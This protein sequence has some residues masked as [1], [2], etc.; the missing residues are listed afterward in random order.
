[1]A[2]DFVEL[3]TLSG[4]RHLLADVYRL[5]AREGESDSRLLHLALRDIV[6]LLRDPLGQLVTNLFNSLGPDDRVFDLLLKPRE[7]L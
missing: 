2:T 4:L 3:D 5:D 1:M 6:R 7:L